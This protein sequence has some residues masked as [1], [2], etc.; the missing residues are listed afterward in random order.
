MLSLMDTCCFLIPLRQWATNSSALNALAYGHLWIMSKKK[1]RP[2]GIRE[3]RIGK[4][5]ESRR[6]EIL[7]PWAVQLKPHHP[8]TIPPTQ[9]PAG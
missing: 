3:G 6:V 7:P 1:M 8:C 2:S 4:M 5:V 9:A